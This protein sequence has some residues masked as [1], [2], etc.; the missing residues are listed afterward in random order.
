MGGVVLF[1]EGNQHH[2]EQFALSTAED[3]GVIVVS[4]RA[5]VDRRACPLCG[6]SSNRIHSR[7]VRTVADLPCGQEDPNSVRCETLRL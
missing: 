6:K 1:S 4:A 2:G 3:E 5:E 7:Y